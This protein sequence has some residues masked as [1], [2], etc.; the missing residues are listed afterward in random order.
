MVDKYTTNRGGRISVTDAKTIGRWLAAQ[1]HCTARQ[2][3]D[4]A[5]PK[6]SEFHHLFNWDDPSE[7]ERARL[8]RAGELIR[9]V[10]VE[11]T[12]SGKKQN[13]RAASSIMVEPDDAEPDDTGAER[14][15]V[16]VR[17]IERSRPMQQ[18][19]IDRGIKALRWWYED[20][21]KYA[22]HFGMVPKAIDNLLKEHDE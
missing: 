7:A 1:K 16:H 18:Q 12:I 2:F 3:L 21:R 22:R 4:A 20:Y 9:T 6:S 15:Y 5:R 10:M 11:R 13:I 14:R 19:I 17:V 8:Q